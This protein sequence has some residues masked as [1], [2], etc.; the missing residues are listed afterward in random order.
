MSLVKRSALHYAARDDDAAKVQALL[1]D[2]ESPDVQDEQGFTPLHLAAQEYSLSAATALLAAGA[3]VDVENAFGNTPLSVAVFGSN[4]RGGIIQLL[5]ARGAD[6]K[7]ENSSGQSPVGLARLI[8][9]YDVAQF[10]LDVP[11]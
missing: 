1:A 8:A 2:G 3:Q 7:H 10:F 9:N 6:P 5:R 4:G 11:E